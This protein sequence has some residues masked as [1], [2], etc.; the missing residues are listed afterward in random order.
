MTKDCF[1]I[2]HHEND[3]NGRSHFIGYISVKGTLKDIDQILKA[4]RFI[5]YS[6]PNGL[7]N[8][9]RWHITLMVRE[10]KPLAELETFLNALG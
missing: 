2:E 9:N 1:V 10:T 8:Y 4:K 6:T 3:D 7:L 5:P